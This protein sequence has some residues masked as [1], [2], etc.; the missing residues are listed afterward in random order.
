MVGV[1]NILAQPGDVDVAVSR[2]EERR[3]SLGC[4]NVATR[5]T[6]RVT[7]RVSVA[8]AITG[9]WSVDVWG[10]RVQDSECSPRNPAPCGLLHT[11]SEL[12]FRFQAC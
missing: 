3:E 1:E 12:E 9:F 10:S 5:L 8:V 7:I 11:L 2:S 4:Y 6:T